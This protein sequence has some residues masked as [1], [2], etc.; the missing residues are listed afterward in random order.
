MKRYSLTVALAFVSGW[1][2]LAASPGY[3]HYQSS[4]NDRQLNTAGPKEDIRGHFEGQGITIK[5]TFENENGK[6]CHT[7][8]QAVWNMSKPAAVLVPKTKL[9]IVV[10]TERSHENWPTVSGAAAVWVNDVMKVVDHTRAKAAGPESGQGSF[11]VPEGGDAVGRTMKI[12]LYGSEWAGGMSIVH[13]YV[14]VDGE[15]PAAPVKPPAS[16]SDLMITPAAD[17]T[18]VKVK[19]SGNWQGSWLN[20]LGESG[21]DTLELK[22]DAEGNLSGTWSGNISVTGVRSS[23]S[24]YVLKG[25]TATRAYRVN[26]FIQGGTLKL[27][28]VVERL[29]SS[30]SYQGESTFAFAQ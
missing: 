19:L 27:T 5:H 11:E 12:G 20:S 6:T 7:T 23:A 15:P 26:G 21:K 29:D 9:N 13:S 30:G 10:K 3:W 14:W 8:F 18:A 16:D 4:V 17:K 2:V 24:Q 25:R 28:Y 22:E 1:T